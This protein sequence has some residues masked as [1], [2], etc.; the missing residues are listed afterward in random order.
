MIKRFLVLLPLLQQ[1]DLDVDKL[2]KEAKWK[3]IENVQDES[4]EVEKITATAGVRGD[5][6]EHEI[7]NYLYYLVSTRTGV[8]SLKSNKNPQIHR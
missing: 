4:Y 8:N 1:E 2:F 7:L 6:A 3:E 5:E